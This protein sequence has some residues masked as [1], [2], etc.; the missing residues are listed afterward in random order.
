MSQL[1]PKSPVIF[2]YVETLY[3]HNIRMVYIP[4][5][6]RGGIHCIVFSGGDGVLSYC[7]LLG[8]DHTLHDETVVARHECGGVVSRRVDR[9]DSHGTVFAPI[10]KVFRRAFSSSDVVGV[11]MTHLLHLEKD[12]EVRKNEVGRAKME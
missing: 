6:L 12:D 11:I 9:G 4:V 3:S 2:S 7:L 5:I 10:A 1:T 8:G